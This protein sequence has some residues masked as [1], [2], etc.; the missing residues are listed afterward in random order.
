MVNIYHH[1]GYNMYEF[2]KV[3]YN[4]TE[5]I[6]ML[7]KLNSKIIKLVIDR[8]YWKLVQKDASEKEKKLIKYKIK[9]IDEK[10]IKMNVP[11]KKSITD[12]IDKIYTA[13]SQANPQL[14]DNEIIKLFPK[15]ISLKVKGE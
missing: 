9:E 5:V 13:F 4:Y 1:F 15:N 10:L 7:I 11:I 14:C 12:S 2:G 8:N 3:R 6:N